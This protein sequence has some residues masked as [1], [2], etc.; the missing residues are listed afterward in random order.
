MPQDQG[1]R[2]ALSQR[3][4][5]LILLTPFLAA[6][7]L[8]LVYPFFKG[9]WISLHDWNLMAVSFNPD[10]KSFVGLRNYERV[11]WG[12]DITWDAFASPALQ[13]IGLLGMLGSFLLY[14]SGRAGR[15]TAIAMGVAALLFFVFPGFTRT[16]AGAGMTA[17]SGPRSPTRSC[18]S[19][20]PCRG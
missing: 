9:V 15:V 12:S 17:A 11:M 20:W 14:R 13:I 1:P 16:R 7:G 3:Q 8:F 6:Y 18:L 10:A 5:A 19:G 4:A 2:L